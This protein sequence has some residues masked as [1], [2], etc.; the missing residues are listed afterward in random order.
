MTVF[1]NMDHS[2][3]FFEVNL[4]IRRLQMAAFHAAQPDEILIGWMKDRPTE[5]HVAKLLR[6]IEDASM[7][8]ARYYGSPAEMSDHLKSCWAGCSSR[9]VSA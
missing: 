8:L 5:E 7:S 6:D 1:K 9:M 2:A 4:R 3:W